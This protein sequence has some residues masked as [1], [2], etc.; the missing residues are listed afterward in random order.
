MARHMSA[1]AF[2][3]GFHT[4]SIVADTQKVSIHAVK[5]TLFLIICGRYR[6][7]QKNIIVLQYLK[8]VSGDNRVRSINKPKL[9][10]FLHP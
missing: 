2:T 8:Q 6:R 1:K 5:F 3:T 4:D 9:I 10:G 7:G